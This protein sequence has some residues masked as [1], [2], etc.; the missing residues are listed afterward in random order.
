[1][2]SWG[3]KK[4]TQYMQVDMVQDRKSCFYLYTYVIMWFGA[5]CLSAYTL[6]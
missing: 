2:E 5:N 1:M 3:S 4:G 6:V